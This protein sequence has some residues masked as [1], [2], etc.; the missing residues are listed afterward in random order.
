MEPT[1]F[2][3]RTRSGE[4]VDEFDR[5]VEVQAEAVRE[6]FEEGAFDPDFRLGLELEGYAVD[7]DGRLTHVPESAFG[8]VCEREL[9]WHNAELNTPPTAFD[10]D[11]IDAQRTELGGRLRGL[12]L[13]L[14]ESGIGFVTDGMW[15]VEPPGGA[16]AYLTDRREEDGLALSTNMSPAARYYA[17]DADITAG[18][19]VE[20]DVPGCSRRFPTILVESLTAS[21]QVHLQVPS[22]ELARYHNAALRTAGPVLA[23]AANAPFLPAGLY[24]DPDPAI[25]LDGPAELR[26]PV[27]EAMNV[28]EPGKVRFPRDVDSPTDVLDRLLADRRCVPC[29]SEWFDGDEGENEGGDRDGDGGFGAEYWELLHRQGTY[30]RWIRPVLGPE[31]FRIEYRLLAAQPTVAD[32]IGFQA[33]VVGLL[34]GIVTSDHPL[35]A[36]PWS[37][38]RESF[39]AAV[40][41]GL[42]ARLSWIDRTGERTTDP[43]RIYDDLFTTAR[44]GLRDRGF[45]PDRI[46]GLLAPIEGRWT[47]RTSP[48]DWKRARVRARLEDG[49]GLERAIEDTGREYVRRATTGEP[50]VEWLR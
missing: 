17:L 15:V 16:F 1:E 4:A 13:L 40:D 11:G 26:V 9:G 23:L 33:L 32:T 28:R 25:V 12:R 30:W 35:A 48:S 8:T 5:R 20:L 45:P 22:S 27:F 38:A 37:D 14:A 42:D 50:F 44:E 6:A 36:L 39:Y 31:G 34:H 18:G 19:A 47:E 43:E 2:V 49:M 10:A 7:G 3:R 21:M 24:D 41:D 46:D 29:L